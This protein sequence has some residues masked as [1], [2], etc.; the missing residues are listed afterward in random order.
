MAFSIDIAEMGDIAARLRK[1][2]AAVVEDEKIPIPDTGVPNETALAACGGPIG[3][4]GGSFIKAIR[5]DAKDLANWLHERAHAVH[6]VILDFQAVDGKEGARYDKAR[7]DL[8]KYHVGDRKQLDT[9][10]GK[11]SELTDEEGGY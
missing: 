5:K 4:A 8:Q 9:M 7:N 1:D 2:H 6:D 3:D 11:D 10:F